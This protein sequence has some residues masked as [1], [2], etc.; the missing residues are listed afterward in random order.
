M[1]LLPLLAGIIHN[2]FIYYKKYLIKKYLIKKLFN[3]K[4]LKFNYYFQMDFF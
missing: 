2:I 3:K 4:F 1:P